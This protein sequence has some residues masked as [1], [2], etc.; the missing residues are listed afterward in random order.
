LTEYIGTCDSDL[1]LPHLLQ[2]C[3]HV[4]LCSDFTSMTAIYLSTAKAV[5]SN[6]DER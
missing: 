4:C 1:P 6:S 3:I 5:L 2:L